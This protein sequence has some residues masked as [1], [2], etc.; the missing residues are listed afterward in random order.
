[1]DRFS[2]FTLWKNFVAC[3]YGFFFEKIYIN[4]KLH[5]IIYQVIFFNFIIN[6]VF[7][8]KI[9]DSQ[10]KTNLLT[11]FGSSIPIYLY[12]HITRFTRYSPCNLDIDSK[13]DLRC[14]CQRNKCKL[15][16][17]FFGLVFIFGFY[18]FILQKLI[19]TSLIDYYSLPKVLSLNIF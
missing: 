8:L 12:I 19:I 17:F 16:I 1:M 13:G 4:I 18:F 7:K 3:W 14:L 5:A 10:D 9:V 2:A 6:I 11:L 15:T